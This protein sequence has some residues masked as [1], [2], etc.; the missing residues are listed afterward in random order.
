MTS[1]RRAVIAN[2]ITDLLVKTGEQQRLLEFI[3]NQLIETGWNEKVKQSCKDY[4]QSKG[5]DNI[6]VE[7]VVQAISPSAKQVIPP[8]VRQD[9]LDQLRKFLVQYDIEV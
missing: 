5:V 2:K 6:S 3:D 4:I 7:M 9:L 1:E 8:A